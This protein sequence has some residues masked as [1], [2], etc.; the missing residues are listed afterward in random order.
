MSPHLLAR[1]LQKSLSGHPI[2]I[3]ES[4]PA[5]EIIEPNKAGLHEKLM[6]VPHA[7]LHKAGTYIIGTETEVF[8]VGEGGPGNKQGAG[9]MGHRVFQHMNTPWMDE[10]RVICM[11]PIMPAEFSRL[12]EQT[13]LAIHFQIA[14]RLP[15]GNSIFR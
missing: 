8:Y 6:A 5:V 2:L 1:M 11:V 7:S 14:G 9:N 12:G 10:A 15:K 3:I 4:G 13:A